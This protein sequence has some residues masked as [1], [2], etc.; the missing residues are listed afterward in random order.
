MEKDRV[1]AE[2]G[3]A[4]GAELREGKPEPPKQPTRRFIGRNTAAANAQK[5]AATSSHIEDSTAIQG[6]KRICCGIASLD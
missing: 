4:V 2:I 1:Q 5:Q 6:L 3:I